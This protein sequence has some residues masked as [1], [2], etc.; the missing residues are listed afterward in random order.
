MHDL[1]YRLAKLG[2]MTMQEH[3]HLN[4]PEDGSGWPPFAAEEI[5]GEATGGDAYRVLT[6]PTFT[7]GIAVDDVVTTILAEGDRWVTGVVT[8]GDHSTVRVIKMER[9]AQSDK[10]ELAGLGCNA[11]EAP[12]AGMV[13]WD[14]PP[15]V[16]FHDVQAVLSSKAEAGDWDYDIGALGR[17]HQ[18]QA[19][20]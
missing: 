1:S 13:A 6:P 8:E 16:N 20:P 7:D 2:S 19:T 17:T 4:L 3:L 5:L 14:V 10:A 11:T 9:G 12:V 15:S 18:E